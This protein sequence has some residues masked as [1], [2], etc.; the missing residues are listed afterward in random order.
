MIWR[1]L[2]SSALAL[3]VTILL[4]SFMVK[5]VAGDSA[6]QMVDQAITQMQFVALPE[7]PPE[8]P[9]EP[10]TATPAALPAANESALMPV[11]SVPQVPAPALDALPAVPQLRNMAV[12]APAPGA[13]WSMPLE[14]DGFEAGE[15]GKGY[16]EVVPL[17]TRRPNIPERA[18]RNKIDGWVLVAFTLKP[19]G[20]TANV[21]V[22][23]ANPGGVFEDNVVRAVQ[24]WLYDMRDVKRK[25]DLILT[26]KVELSW[27]DFPDNSPYL[28]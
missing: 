2:G 3:L 12:N 4:F 1:L 8:P 13:N 10:D 22:L 7:E 26:Q 21:R 11:A 19:D 14:A 23:D 15:K 5:L 27:R 20:R 6:R 17:A 16:V 28:D 24:D 25:G 18:W 9:P